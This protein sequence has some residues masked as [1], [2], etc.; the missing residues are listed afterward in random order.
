MMLVKNQLFCGTSQK[1]QWWF[2]VFGVG[3]SWKDIR[4]HPLLFSERYGHRKGL[5]IGSWMFH[6]LPFVWLDN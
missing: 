4:I 2:R 6:F 3:V 1:G 5:R